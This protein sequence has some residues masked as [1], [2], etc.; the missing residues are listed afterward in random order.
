MAPCSQHS[1]PRR[2]REPESLGL[3][4]GIGDCHLRRPPAGVWLT[5]HRHQRP[6]RLAA[7]GEGVCEE[8]LVWGEDSCALLTATRRPLC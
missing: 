8:G 6:G 4:N 5:G 7:A 3:G 1:P 2:R